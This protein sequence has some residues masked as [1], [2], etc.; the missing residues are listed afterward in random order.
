[1][2]FF[3]REDIKLFKETNRESKM[4]V[5]SI[6]TTAAVLATLST[7]AS[8]QSITTGSEGV[9]APAASST[10]TPAIATGMR[11]VL[12][13]R[14][15]DNKENNNSVGP[16]LTPSFDLNYKSAQLALNVFYE[17][18]MSTARVFGKG[19]S[20]SRSMTENSYFYHH[21]VLTAAFAFAPNWSLVNLTEGTA[22]MSAKDGDKSVG[23]TSIFDIERKINSN[24]SIAVGYRL[25]Y[26]SKFGQ[27][28]EGVGQASTL[29]AVEGR[30]ALASLSPAVQAQNPNFGENPGSIIHS[31]IVTA[32]TKLGKIGYKTYAQAGQGTAKGPSNSTFY[33][34]RWN[35]DVSVSPVRNLDL[36]LRYR[37]NIS[38][39]EG[40]EKGSI[41][42][43][44][45][46]IANYAL[47]SQVSVDL[48]NTFTASQSRDNEAATYENENYLGVSYK[49]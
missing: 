14:F 34:Y 5:T 3:F 42:N 25:D 44:G 36:A 16:F 21:P 23:V 13:G 17:L 39:P 26:S 35:N 48:S 40:A 22:M 38:N 15:A 20:G 32:K 4:K 7:T 9:N 31:G 46:V 6:L 28:I 45:R 30:A 41:G 2:V 10:I 37:L 8:A 11:S 33:F 18:E 24:L 12:S 19:V 49:F 47:T 29:S 1:L 27:L 43:V